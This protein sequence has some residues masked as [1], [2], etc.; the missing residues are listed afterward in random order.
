MRAPRR[1]N[2]GLPSLSSGTSSRIVI[3]V[4]APAEN[5]YKNA[6]AVVG[7]VSNNATI[8]PKNVEIIIIRDLYLIEELCNSSLDRSEKTK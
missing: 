4:I 7:S 5:A 6:V 8:A 3:Y 1:K 2:N